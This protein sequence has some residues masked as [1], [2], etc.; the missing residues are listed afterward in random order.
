MITFYRNFFYRGARK[1]QV[2]RLLKKNSKTSGRKNF[3]LAVLVFDQLNITVCIENELEYYKCYKQSVCKKC[4]TKASVG[5]R[6]L[7]LRFLFYRY[8][9][10]KCETVETSVSTGIKLNIINILN[11]RINCFTPRDPWGFN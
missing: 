1:V 2:Q 8:V 6:F 5:A 4:S 10:G 3:K 7:N 11:D 9:G